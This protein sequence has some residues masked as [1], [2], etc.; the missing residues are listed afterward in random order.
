MGGQHTPLRMW[1]SLVSARFVQT[2]AVLHTHMQKFEIPCTRLLCSWVRFFKWTKSG[3]CHA[4]MG[5]LAWFVLGFSVPMFHQTVLIAQKTVHVKQEPN[6]QNARSQSTCFDIDDMAKVTQHNRLK[7]QASK[8]NALVSVWY[9]VLLTTQ[10][11][12]QQTRIEPLTWKV[13]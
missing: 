1:H 4:I 9:S 5:R 8:S 12:F 11:D 10:E 6:L 2:E 7:V 3:S 13:V